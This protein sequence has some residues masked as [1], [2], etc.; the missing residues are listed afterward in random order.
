MQ[1]ENTVA[2]PGLR[3]YIYFTSAVTGAAILV[4]EILG[5]KML[6][7]YIGSSHFVWTAQ[8]AVTLVSLACGYYLGG[9]M[10]D[11]N[12]RLG[13][14]YGCL[15]L[16][17]IYLALTTL[18]VERVTYSFLEGTNLPVAALGSSMFLFF[19]PL[20]L[21]AA[22]GPFLIRVLT[23]SVEKVGGQ[24]GRL[25][26]ISTFGSVAGTVMIGYVL[27]P[28]LPNSQTMFMSSGV[29]LAL[30]A[31]YF[32]FWGRHDSKGVRLLIISALILGASAY[33]E[34]KT[35][36][37][38]KMMTRRYH[39]NSN[40]GE[41]QV[42]ESKNGKVRYY[43]NDYLVQNTYDVEQKKSLS[44]FTYM[45]HELAWAYG[46]PLKQVL[47][48]GM[49]VGIVPMALSNEGVHC[50]VVEINDAIVPVAKEFF[51]FNEDKKRV[52]IA[53]GRFVVNQSTNRYEAILL[54]AFLGDSS[55]SH[56]MTKEAFSEMARLL[57]DDGVLV[58]NS[59]GEFRPGL[60]FFMGSLHKTLGAVFKN[61]K[62]HAQGNGNVFFAASQKPLEAKPRQNIRGATGHLTA[63]IY[64]TMIPAPA[65]NPASGIVL[66]DDYNP[67]EFYDAPN[68]EKHR[69]ALALSVKS[70]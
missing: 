10:A 13:R 24:V 6:S 59:F 16:A 1:S 8:I 12:P 18:V 2:G 40:Y 53:D 4:V 58:I 66:T 65:P 51:D 28:L 29:L 25:S 37:P 54:D 7:P 49:G 48:I 41:L 57:G 45:L 32:A 52:I 56:L 9:R 50:D 35:H 14:L 15:A 31:V 11:S 62:I 64:S 26:A 19:V 43:L 38:L 17:A 61:V 69:R 39:G 20:T 27:L 23:E 46:P 22:T 47:C 44:L 42:L 21:M 36:S 70:L 30:G 68:R 33:V 60:D 34:P 3:R 5:A 55:P 67:V 63:Q